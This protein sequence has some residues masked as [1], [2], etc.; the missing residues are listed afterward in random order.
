MQKGNRVVQT[1]LPGKGWKTFAFALKIGYNDAQMNRTP[2][3]AWIGN[4]SMGDQTRRLPAM[5]LRDRVTEGMSGF[6]QLVAKIPGYKGYKQKE[7][8][9][10]ADKLLRDHI[11]GVLTAQRGRIE[12]IQGELGVEQIEY[13][14]QIGKA[15]RRL[16]TLADTVHTAAYGYAGLFDAVKVKEEELDALYD[17]DNDLLTQSDAIAPALDSLQAAMDNNE[18]LKG[19][20]R[21]LTDVVTQ[22]QDLY[23]RRQDVIIGRA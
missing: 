8:R 14:E 9:R 18:S 22:L 15:R 16:Q 12:D 21:D 7:M 3:C 17:F 11:Y 1:D 10:E 20:I 6:E 4:A 23:N 19:A 13:V 2:G 5:D